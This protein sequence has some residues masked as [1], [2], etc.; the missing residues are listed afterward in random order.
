MYIHTYIHLC[1]PTVYSYD[2]ITH[3]MCSRELCD[4]VE[5]ILIPSGDRIKDLVE[6]IFEVL[7]A[8]TTAFVYMH[9]FV[10]TYVV[11]ICMYVRMYVCIQSMS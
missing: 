6:E 9:V 2:I 4:C 7:Y 5:A 10:C 3:V 8:F 11:Y 1:T